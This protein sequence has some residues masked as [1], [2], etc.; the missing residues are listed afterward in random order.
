MSRATVFAI[1]MTMALLSTIGGLI[2]SAR[3]LGWF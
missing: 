1:I 2:G 3:L